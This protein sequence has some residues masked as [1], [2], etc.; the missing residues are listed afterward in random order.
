[1]TSTSLRRKLK[2]KVLQ[3]HLHIL[4]SMILVI[5]LLTPFTMT[6]S[7]HLFQG[8]R[9]IQTRMM[10]LAILHGLRPNPKLKS[11]LEG[12]TD[13]KHLWGT[14][15]H[16]HNLFSRPFF[17]PQ[18]VYIRFTHIVNMQ[19]KF[20]V[21]SAMH[22]TLDREYSRSRKYLQL[23]NE[24]LVQAELALRYWQDHDN[25]YIWAPIPI[26][27]DRTD[28]RSLEMAPHSGVATQTQLSLH[29]SILPP[30]EGYPQKTPSQHNAQ[31]GLATLW[32][33]AKHKFTPKL[34]R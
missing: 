20:Y 2:H 29:M 24:R 28:Y 13:L 18:S 27:T 12:C 21:G 31:F 19:P 25:L 17:Q 26:Y 11:I 33:R 15:L 8:F 32:R 34:V 5:Y 16:S 22:H 7:I 23:T 30:K 3:S 14:T 1:M 10:V 6:H 9:I 4:H